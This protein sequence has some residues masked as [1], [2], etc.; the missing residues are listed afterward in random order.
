MAII[1][2]TNGNDALNGTTDDDLIN[3]LAGDDTLNGNGG[4]DTLDGG[5][6]DDTFYIDSYTYGDISIAGGGGKDKFVYTLNENGYGTNTIITDFGGIG[7]GSNPSSAAIPEVDTLQFKGSEQLAAK[8]LQLTQN[9]NDLGI[10]FEGVP[11]YRVVLQNFALENLDNLA[12]VGNI[13][14]DGQTS[15]TDSFDVFNANSTQ[16]T[17]FNKNTVTFLNDLNNN[18]NGFDNSDD[19]INGQGGDDIIDGKSGNDILRGGA[20]NDILIGGA[21]ND[22]LIGDSGNNTLNGG[23]G[24]DYLSADSI[25]NYVYGD[26]TNNNLLS[27]GDG[28]D[29]LFAAIFGNST[30]NGGTGD[31]TI[32][33]NVA[34]NDDILIT[35][36]GG[37]DKFVYQAPEFSGGNSTITIADFGGTGK[38]SNPSLAVI[39]ELD[40]LQF[41]GD[42]QLTARNLRLTQN[43]DNTEIIFNERYGSKVVLQNFALENLDNLAQVGNILFYGQTNI[44]D[45]FDV[46]NANS[47]E[48]TIFNKNTVT[49]LNDLNNNVN[50][51]DN[52][53]D[54][55]N[56]QGGNDI[57][58]GKSGNDL[59]RGGAGND[60][61]I[62]GAGNDQLYGNEGNNT[63]DGGLG[64]DQLDG[65]YSTGNNVFNGGSGSDTL[66]LYYST[67]NNKLSGDEGN[68]ALYISE[69]TGN[70]TL[71]G[72]DGADSFYAD[73]IQ[74]TNIFDGGD[75]NDSFFLSVVRY[76]SSNL[77][78]ETVDGGA[79]D[80]L[81]SVNYGNANGAVTFTFNAIT[82]TGSI[83]AGRNQVSF[84]NIEGLNITGTAYNDYLV[85]TDRDDTLSGSENPLSGGGNDT[86]IG[87]AGNDV[88]S[89]GG[90]D[91][92]LYGDTGNDLLS[93]FDSSADNL[94][95]GGDGNDSL[96]GSGE[97]YG[98]GS[99]DNTL[100]GGT[101]DDSLTA[102]FAT[103]NNLL[104][105][106]DGN[107]YLSISDSYY[108]EGYYSASGDNT[109]NGGTGNDILN[110]AYTTGDNLLYGGDGNDS[111]Y[112]GSPPPSPYDPTYSIPVNQTVDGGTG[113]DF[114]S[115]DY[116]NATGGVTTTFNAATNIGLITAGTNQL[117]YKNIERF[118]IT[119]TAYNDNIV[120][121]SGNDTLST[122][123]GGNDT[124]DGGIGDDLLSVDFSDATAGITSTFN[125]TTNIGSITAGTNQVSY[126]NIE[127][128]NILGT[129]YDDSI[130]G[131]SS[132]DT[133][134]GGASGNDTIDGGIGDDLL[135]VDFRDA[136]AGIT[137]TFNPTTNIGSITA[138]TNQVS[139]Q[140]IERLNISGTAYDDN[141][142][143]NNGN[144]TLFGGTG[145]N[146][147]L[148]GGDGNDTFSF[149]IYGEGL[150]RVD[151][152]NVA[153]EFI[154][155][156]GDF[157]DATFSLLK[158]QFTIGASATTSAQ[159]FIYDSTTGG[160]YFDRDGSASG[161]TQVEFAQLSAGLSLTENN[162]VL[163]YG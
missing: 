112:I 22:T 129:A 49:F 32:Y 16:S 145:G 85:G 110:T 124:I 100:Y 130:V 161:Y 97:Y 107:D 25:S 14:F 77:T 88:L 29:T 82:N 54:V 69:S 105:G 126:K 95:F 135:S 79:G 4:Y 24:D 13:L 35:G 93:V 94:L 139:Y 63:L 51:F 109:L 30:L 57:I 131:N 119:G 117:S 108:D 66:N 92:T 37:K 113:D 158:S 78:T 10:R 17:I 5:T 106:G 120:G 76:P 80:D 20:G 70:N 99:G 101:G 71:S 44:T 146:D 122:G 142:V 3:G 45:S 116:R 144:D 59:L 118:D 39:G 62:G 136:T 81:L 115:V 137:T 72:G 34:N 8:N 67:G 15:I 83:T 114:L 38:G 7:K 151:D 2:G 18:V 90:G 91:S 12:Q 148:T 55:I 96:N 98:F 1:N 157:Y 163:V 140:N 19:V 125:P 11:F 61:L 84:K 134:S 40:T 103:G 159:R 27:G 155:V 28:N 60:I 141:I 111:F 86:I 53:N 121:N 143:G 160:L 6:G 21:G 132:N 138:G 68:D 89:A 102:R 46:F 74:G 65:V 127:R 43:G 31:D 162:F 133:L 58:D 48:S 123:N 149:N 36:G 73:R 64:N 156:S 42:E 152:F 150:T 23:A 154:Q 9:G 128:L 104:D 75:G 153:N 87:G 50:G 41:T 56:G 52:S 147:I 33:S 47:T 26:P